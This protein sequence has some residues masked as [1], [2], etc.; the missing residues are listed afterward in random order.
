MVVNPREGVAKKSYYSSPPSREYRAKVQLTRGLYTQQKF[1]LP[2]LVVLM[3][4]MLNCR[5]LELHDGSRETVS[6][7]AH[8]TDGDCSFSPGK[9]RVSLLLTHIH[10]DHEYYFIGR[11]YSFKSA[12][13]Y[14]RRKRP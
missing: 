12:V 2:A 9:I 6:I 13:V 3:V 11:I 8:L 10:Y 5:K 14:R 4:A 7:R 1:T